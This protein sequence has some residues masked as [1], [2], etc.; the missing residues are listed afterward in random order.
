MILTNGEHG[1]Y[2]VR[3]GHLNLTQTYLGQQ[4]PESGPPSDAEGHTS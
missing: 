3:Q 2:Q 1:R 4:Y